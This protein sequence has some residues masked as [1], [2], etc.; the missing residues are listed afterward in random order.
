[1]YKSVWTNKP[2]LHL[3][4]HWNWKH[5]DTVDV[6]AYY[7]NADEVELFL[8]GKSLGIKKKM[9]DDLHVMWRV[10]FEAGELKAVSRK[11]GKIVL[12]EVKKTAGTPAKIVLIADKKTIK[13]D[14][15][16]LSFIT[17]RVEDKDGNLV[18]DADNFI[19]FNVTG[20]GIV[21]GTDNGNET[22]MESFKASQHKS[23]NGLC[24]LVVQSNKQKGN[25]N[26]T[27]TSTGLTSALTTVVTQ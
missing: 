14:G 7:N 16:G 13:A 12:T 17:V 21:A 3:L 11:N 6:W 2:V 24:L 20:N 26:I 9:N 10:P 19:K 8:N 22:S 25:I 1:M 18:P 5:G 23:F 27:A 4:P 15:V